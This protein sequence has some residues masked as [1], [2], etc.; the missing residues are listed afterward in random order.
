[1]GGI[2]PVSTLSPEVI[3]NR[4]TWAEALK[5]GKYPQTKGFLCLT[6]GGKK[7]YCCLGVLEE[8]FDPDSLVETAATA[9]SQKT[10]DAIGIPAYIYGNLDTIK[11]NNAFANMNDHEGKTF[12]EIADYIEANIED[13][14]LGVK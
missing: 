5:S 11:I 13:P 8:L 14:D 12:A 2:P 6:D 7:S 1:M 10:C 9:V 3:A 4:K